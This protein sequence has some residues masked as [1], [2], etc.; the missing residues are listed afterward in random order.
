MK[1]VRQTTPMNCGWACIAM[2]EDGEI[3][4]KEGLSVNEMSQILTEKTREKWEIYGT[5]EEGPEIPV[6][7]PIQFHADPALYLITSES[8]PFEIVGETP[9]IAHWIIYYNDTIYDP[10]MPAS[11]SIGEYPK[12]GWHFLRRISRHERGALRQSRPGQHDWQ[13]RD[14]SPNAE[15]RSTG[16]E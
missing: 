2:L 13:Q 9:F 3:L 1:F 12:R 6:P 14:E 15:R 5:P 11:L 4:G 10:E 8:E 7:L 16:P